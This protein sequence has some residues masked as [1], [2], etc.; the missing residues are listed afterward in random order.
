MTIPE[1]LDAIIKGF[2][3]RLTHEG[4]AHRAKVDLSPAPERRLLL[5]RI[6]VDED[7]RSQGIA[8]RSSG[9]AFSILVRLSS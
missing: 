5:D 6:V 7:Q 2:E 4:L 9:T 3:L 1:S 8:D